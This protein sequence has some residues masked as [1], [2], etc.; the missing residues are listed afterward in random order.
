MT[1]TVKGETVKVCVGLL[2]SNHLWDS[3]FGTL[4]KSSNT[5]IFPSGK[6]SEKMGVC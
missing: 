1:Q 2:I 6:P 4:T 5:Y 3:S